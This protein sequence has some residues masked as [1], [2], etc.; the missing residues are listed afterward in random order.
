MEELKKEIKDHF[1]KS[2]TDAVYYMVTT[3]CPDI[4]M[5]ELARQCFGKSVAWVQQRM[6]GYNVNGKPARFTAEE[7][8]ML[9]KYLRDLSAK[10]NEVAD[11][12]N[13]A[14]E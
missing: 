3:L 5:S 1:A 12:I 14:P 10:I 13:N 7:C 9:C 4:N 11:M 2:K 6:H 8:D